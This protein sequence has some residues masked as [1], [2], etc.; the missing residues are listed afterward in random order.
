MKQ[1]KHLIASLLPFM[2]AALVSAQTQ[3]LVITVDDFD[4]LN[5]L[6]SGANN[7]DI[8]KS[9]NGLQLDFGPGSSNLGRDAYGTGTST[10][11]QSGDWFDGSYIKFGNS[12]NQ[13]LL[14]FRI[15]NNTAYDVKLKN[16]SFDI[17]RDPANSNPTGF[18]LKYL[19][20][21]DSNLVKGATAQTGTEIVDLNNIGSDSVVGGINNFSEVIG[22]NI[23][24]TAWIA[25]GEYANLR[26]KMIT[27]NSAASSQLDNFSVTVE[28]VNV[29][30]PS[31][32]AL[33]LGL[34]GIGFALLRRRKL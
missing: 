1:H 23:S 24:G 26:I 11:G 14:D 12:G 27:S 4:G 9:E 22:A 7:L 19:A 20:S 6:G 28:A 33:L 18:E 31:T 2:V 32:Y 3:S 21:G 29:P 16:V 15:T 13:Q 10:F 34:I 25:A 5:S 17:R 30:E 8:T